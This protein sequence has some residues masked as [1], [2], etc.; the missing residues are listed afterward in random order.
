MS[1][2]CWRQLLRRGRGQVLADRNLLIVGDLNSPPPNICLSRRPAKQGSPT[3]SSRTGAAIKFSHSLFAGFC[4]GNLANASTPG[5]F[6]QFIRDK[7]SGLGRVVLQL[8]AALL[9]RGSHEGKGVWFK[10]EHVVSKST[11][12][13]SYIPQ[14][15]FDT[16]NLRR[17]WRMSSLS[18]AADTVWSY[19][20]AIQAGRRCLGREIRSELE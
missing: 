2:A 14:S 20:R 4:Q 19:S 13:R 12:S 15:S 9:K 8:L 10:F 7:L 18:R 17:L 3:A 6:L 5:A 1:T 16:V 11:G